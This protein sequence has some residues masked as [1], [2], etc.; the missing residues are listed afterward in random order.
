MKS[1]CFRSCLAPRLEQF[2]ALRQASGYD[3]R[4]QAK[5]LQYFD[6]FLFRNDIRVERL[7][8]ELTEQ[9]ERTLGHL[10]PATRENRLR[11]LIRFARHLAA[12]DPE[13]FVP[14]APPSDRATRARLPFIY[15][16]EHVRALMQAAGQLPPAASLRP[17]TYRA[18]IGLL[19]STGL[20]I[21]E[22][23]ALDLGDLDDGAK[24]LHVRHGKF[25]KERWAPLSDSAYAALRGFLDRRLATGPPAGAQPDTPLFINL[26]ARRLDYSTVLHTFQRLLADRGLRPAKGPRPRIHDM[27]HTFAVHSLLRWYRQGRDLNACL[28]ALSTYMGHVGVAATQVYLHATAELLDATHRRFL[29]PYRQHAQGDSDDRHT[30]DRSVHGTVLLP[31]SRR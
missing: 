8:R 22:A 20:R 21:S 29:A 5:E 4:G 25:G 16:L 12:A 26:R 28:P 23:L 14:W 11:V 27:R 2:V 1:P 17:D 6:T 10:H 7:T 24:L 30:P 9:Y 18:L 31:V 13:S 19:Y 15:A 3:Y